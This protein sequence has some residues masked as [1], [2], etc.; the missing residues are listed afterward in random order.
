MPAAMLFAKQG[1]CPQKT[2]MR[3]LQTRVRIPDAKHWEKRPDIPDCAA[4]Q[5]GARQFNWR[6]GMAGQAY[7]HL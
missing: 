3:H 6:A 7:A 5:P 4:T 1:L 2:T